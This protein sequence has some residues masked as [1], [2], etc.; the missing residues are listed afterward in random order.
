MV[1]RVRVLLR[2]RGV[3]TRMCVCVC[4]LIYPQFY[5]QVVVAAPDEGARFVRAAVH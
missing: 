3:S 1:P 2:T 5:D 4:V